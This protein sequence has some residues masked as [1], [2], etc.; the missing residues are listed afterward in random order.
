[1]AWNTSFRPAVLLLQGCR[2]AFWFLLPGGKHKVGGHHVSWRLKKADLREQSEQQ[3]KTKVTDRRNLTQFESLAPVF[4]KLELQPCPTMVSLIQLRTLPPSI[5][6]Q[7]FWDVVWLDNC[8]YMSFP[9]PILCSY[10][11]GFY[12]VTTQKSVVS[13]LSWMTWA[14]RGNGGSHTHT[15]THVKTACCHK[16]KE[17]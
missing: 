5:L 8:S 15:H 6:H 3:R 1:M 7:M 17:E 11:V 13:L 12:S 16:G 9:E 14:T 4:A 10:G 2:P